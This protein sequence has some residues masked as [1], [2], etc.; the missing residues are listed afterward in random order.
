MKKE[1]FENM[2]KLIACDMDGTLLD[3]NKELPENF[4]YVIDEMRK[5]NVRFV[6]ASGRSWQA[7]KPLFEKVPH[8]EEFIYICD[9]GGN[10]VYPDGKHETDI[11][12]P[13]T[14]SEIIED[15]EVFGDIEPVLCCVEDIYYPKKAHDEFASE[16]TNFYIN[17]T[18]VDD[19]SKVKANV[20]KIAV[21][22]MQGAA[23]H[24]YPTF[25]KKYGK[26]MDCVVSG[27]FWMD[28]MNKGIN[29][30][31]ALKKI[32][33]YTSINPEETMAFG[34]YFNDA[35]MLDACK[36]GYVMENACDDMKKGRKLIAPP[37]TENGVLQIV[38][39]KL[40]IN[41]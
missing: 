32:M 5:K 4:N 16:I 28:L 9:N 2:I 25:H 6:A 34:D 23:V 30:G 21:C 3:E 37:N 40:N 7:L 26:T 38:C 24:S 20:I 29:K 27:K 11:I 1:L 39:D 35:P 41:F 14:V 18:A 12:S 36:Y 31:N 22:D 10:I 19:I 15:C 13:E 33:K 17:F 8:S